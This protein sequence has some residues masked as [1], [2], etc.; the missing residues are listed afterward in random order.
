MNKELSSILEIALK[1]SLVAYE[2]KKQPNLLGALH[3]YHD[4]EDGFLVFF[5]D[6]DNILNKVQLTDNQLHNLTHSL[7][8]VLHQAGKERLFDND[9]IVKPFVVNLVDK[10]FVVLDELFFLDDDSPKNNFTWK[11]IEKDL[12][13][14]LENL[15]K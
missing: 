14:F 10:D 1:E 7:R 3:L 13:A 5:D 15:L 12:D 6:A 9:Y 2:S 8:Q 4:Y 11:N